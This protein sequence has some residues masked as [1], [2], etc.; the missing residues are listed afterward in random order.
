MFNLSI[1]KKYSI[2]ESGHLDLDT[3]YQ[4]YPKV[5]P[6][7][8]LKPCGLWYAYGE[9]WIDLILKE[10]PD[11]ELVTNLKNGI[12]S[13]FELE[14][15]GNIIK[16]SSAQDIKNF[17]YKY[18][19]DNEKINW[20]YVSSVYD[21]IE[22]NPFEKEYSKHLWYKTFDIKSGCIWNFNAIKNLTRIC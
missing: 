21:G 19:I 12:I 3:K 2:S 14:L 17:H 7:K 20:L 1:D 6:I 10:Y 13:I 22:I 11:S 8:G 4:Q 9:E 15:A 18:S 16:L 5:D